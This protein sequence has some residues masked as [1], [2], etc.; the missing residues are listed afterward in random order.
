M[1]RLRF[2]RYR[3]ATPGWRVGRNRY[4]VGTCCEQTIGV[5]AVLGA[6]A[7]GMTW[8]SPRAPSPAHEHRMRP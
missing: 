1:A 3:V 7:Y 5:E 6:W 8:R 2:T 4:Y